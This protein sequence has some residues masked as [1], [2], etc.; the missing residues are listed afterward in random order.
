MLGP[1]T[2]ASVNAHKTMPLCKDAFFAVHMAIVTASIGKEIMVND[3]CCLEYVIRQLFNYQQVQIQ[4]R[5]DEEN[6]SVQLRVLDWAAVENKYG[7][8]LPE[9]RV[10]LP[11][12]TAS[13]IVSVTAKVPVYSQIRPTHYLENS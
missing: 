13:A 11:Q 9:K 5:T 12:C 3:G 8:L 6:S 4:P 2:M 1:D 10:A 7:E